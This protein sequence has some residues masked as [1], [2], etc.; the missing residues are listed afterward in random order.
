VRDQNNNPVYR[1]AVRWEITDGPG[2]LVSIETLTDLQGRAEAVIE[3]DGPGQTEVRASLIADSTVFDEAVKNW[4]RPAARV[5][6]LSPSDSTN[7]VGGSRTLTAVVV[8]ASGQPVPNVNL[9]WTIASGP[10]SFVS[11][12]NT[13]NAQG[14]AQAAVTSSSP[15]ETVIGVNVTGQVSINDTAEI[16]W[17]GSTADDLVLTP[18]TAF[19]RTGNNRTLTATVTDQ[20]GNPLS[21][22]NITWTIV[23]GPG[24]I[25]TRQAATD[26][27]GRATAVITST[28]V[29]TT[30]I[31]ATVT[32]ITTISDT[33]SI[34]WTTQEDD[35]DDN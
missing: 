14:R 18:A 13:T 7:T 34:T 32:S 10:G 23:S 16:T 26:A 20:F 15:G 30:V 12:Q 4:V 9:T 3:S 25:V 33:S 6:D 24:T 1:A 29:G 28:T 31:R 17:V 11:R 2:D 8:D 21:G 27:N 19:N 5:L 35:D 22:V